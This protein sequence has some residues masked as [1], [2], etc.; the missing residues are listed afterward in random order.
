MISEYRSSRYLQSG[1]QGYQGTGLHG[2]WKQ[3]CRGI[4]SKAC[5]VSG[6]GSEW[7]FKVLGGG[8]GVAITC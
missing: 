8:G 4:W 7:L 1:L 5:M 3:V 6:F 2:I